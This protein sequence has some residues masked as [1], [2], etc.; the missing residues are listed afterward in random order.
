MN[1][2]VPN[3][4][5]NFYAFRV[6]VILGGYFILFFI[7]ILFFV[8]KKD[9]SQMRWMQYIGLWTIPFAY[10]AG[11]AGW[12]VAECGRQPWAIRDMLPT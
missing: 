1:Q 10:I 2:L 7:A 4:P 5:L 12:V 11:Q 9:L 6:M 8:Y 3:V